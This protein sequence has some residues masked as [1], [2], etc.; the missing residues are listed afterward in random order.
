MQ[1]DCLDGEELRE[2]KEEMARL[3]EQGLG[4]WQFPQA[5]VDAIRC[6]GAVSQPGV[7]APLGLPF[8]IMAGNQADD[9]VHPFWFVRKYRCASV[10]LCNAACSLYL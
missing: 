10:C 5:I 2:R 4:V 8:M 9:T 3:I 6:D 1:A 7:G